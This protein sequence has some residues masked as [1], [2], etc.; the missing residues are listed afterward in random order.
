[1]VRT[2]YEPYPKVHIVYNII[3]T[4]HPGHTRRWFQ[5]L[6]KH[7]Q[8]NIPEASM[9]CLAGGI[10]NCESRRTSCE[11][12][13]LSPLSARDRAAWKNLA[14]LEQ[15]PRL[16]LVSASFMETPGGSGSTKSIKV[17]T[18][19]RWSLLSMAGDLA[20]EISNRKRWNPRQSTD[21]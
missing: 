10:S 18:E 20:S 13:V 16:F 4:E 17:S 9:P 2:Q 1:M 21:L 5:G 3:V 8:M 19:R 11:C 6:N 7:Q 14:G 15:V 12:I